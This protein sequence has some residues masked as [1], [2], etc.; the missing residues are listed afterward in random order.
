MVSTDL[1]QFGLVVGP[2][3]SLGGNMVRV[4]L[5]Q[6]LGQGLDGPSIHHP[7]SPN[8]HCPNS[9]NI[10]PNMWD[11]TWGPTLVQQSIIPRQKHPPAIVAA[12]AQ[13]GVFP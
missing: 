6:Q 1:L 9:P 10:F 7:N 12:Y 11:P 4:L 13:L 2:L 8:M 3:L 5:G